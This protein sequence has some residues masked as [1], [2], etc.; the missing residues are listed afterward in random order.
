LGGNSLLAA[1][2]S[3]TVAASAIDELPVSDA[4]PDF[5]EYIAK[6]EKLLEKRFES[7]S[8]F[9]AGYIRLE[10]ARVMNECLG[11]TR[12]EKKLTE[13]INGIDYYLKIS[14]KLSFDSDV[15]PYVGYSL[16]PMLLLARAI[17]TCA[18]ERRETRGA[19]I[20]EDHPDRN[21]EYEYCSVC[22]YKNGEHR[23]SFEKEDEE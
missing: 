17:L 4:A 16:R 3:G 8:R 11:I 18:L 7:Q 23:V 2:Y 5:G 20:R 22:D 19:H 9:S 21:A 10:L 13:G 14:E 1:I 15:S 12:N 6:Q